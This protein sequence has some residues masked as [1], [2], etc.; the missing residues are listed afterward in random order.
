MRPEKLRKHLKWL[1]VGETLVFSTKE[2]SN[3]TLKA[4]C[5]QLSKMGYFFTTEFDLHNGITKIT[6]K[7]ENRDEMQGESN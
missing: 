2:Y 3:S 4:T 5:S 1:E 7:Y 6:K